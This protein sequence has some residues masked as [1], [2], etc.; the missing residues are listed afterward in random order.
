M[1]L[2]D[3]IAHAGFQKA[4][5]LPVCSTLM[6]LRLYQSSVKPDILAKLLSCTPALKR[7]D[8]EYWASDQTFNFL[9]CESLSAA[10]DSV[11]STLEHLR[12]FCQMY[13]P[14]FEVHGKCH[15]RDFP[16]LSSLH[17]SPV[18]IQGGKASIGPRIEEAI[19]SS[20]EELCFVY[21]DLLLF[22]SLKGMISF[23][24][25]FFQGDW[26]TR[27]PKLQCVYATDN[28]YWLDEARE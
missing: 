13:S 14:E 3:Q 7:L 21:D 23:L 19:P 28:Q 5:S 4:V 24:D 6:T 2:M 20:M 25:N 27:T 22:W 10:L 16:V 18:M 1:N 11:K 12:F 26:R 8:Y 9:D 15:F 17:L